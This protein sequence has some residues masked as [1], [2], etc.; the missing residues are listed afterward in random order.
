M[1]IYLM[2]TKGDLLEMTSI[3]IQVKLSKNLKLL[4]WLFIPEGII[5]IT[6]LYEK[7]S[8]ETYVKVKVLSQNALI[9]QCFINKTLGKRIMPDIPD[10]I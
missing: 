8:L 10:K 2:Q 3:N 6:F 9:D 5:K 1:I 7:Q 4:F